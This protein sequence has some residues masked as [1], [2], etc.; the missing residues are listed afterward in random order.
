MGMLGKHKAGRGL[1]RPMQKGGGSSLDGN[2][3][4][5]R[6][7]TKLYPGVTALDGVSIDFLPGEV[8]A[9]VGENGAGK[10]TLIKIISGAIEPTSGEIVIDGKS[11]DFISPAIS[12]EK[13]ISVVYQE[14]TLV[15]MLSAAENIFLGSFITRHGICDK[16][17]MNKR[18]AELFEMLKINISPEVMVSD[19]TTGYQQ[20]VEI[21]KAVSKNPRIMIMDEPSAPLTLNEVEAMFTIIETLKK[22]GVTIIYISHRM[23]EIFRV[24]DRVTVLRDGRYISTQNVADT[25]KNELI[26][27]MVGRT[28]S[29]TYPAHGHTP[30]DVVLQVKD[31]CGNGVKDISFDLRQGEIL[32]FGGLIGAGRTELFQM[33]FG[34]AKID[35]G[36][37]FFK[38]R[39]IRPKKPETAVA[40]GI[41]LVP[42]DRKRQGLILD[43]SIKDNIAISTLKRISKFGVVPPKAEEEIADRAVKNLNIK[44]PGIK[45]K[46]LNLSG[47]NQQKV[48]LGKWLE[49]DP[50]I[51]ILDE[52]TRG[53]DVGA[54]Q[55]IYKIMVDIV[56]RGKSIIMIS[57][58]MEELLGMSDRVI[59]LSR[60]RMSAELKKEDFSQEK[61]LRASAEI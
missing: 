42:E 56:A 26:K 37:I 7:I 9:I 40:L 60:G 32:G 23:D 1:G 28:L 36:E 52:P 27:L 13:G 50:E 31:L 33:I 30:G 39:N 2:I 47:G 45:Q 51:L 5:L 54:K 61:M 25:N 38:R 15:P 22:E 53:I 55:E 18:S 4:S 48:V 6:N 11:F 59:V 58:E 10:S 24:A 14:F 16:R 8:H 35:S 19:L 57:S 20:I 49:T 29:E 21:A 41:S 46:V 12:Q 17:A 44:T 43:R 34:N 3:L